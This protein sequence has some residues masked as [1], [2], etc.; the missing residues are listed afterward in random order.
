VD[1][2]EYRGGVIFRSVR[3]GAFFYVL[4]QTVGAAHE[5]MR[6]NGYKPFI[7]DYSLRSMFRT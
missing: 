1:A 6:Q 4:P 3:A 2:D 7:Y 5:V